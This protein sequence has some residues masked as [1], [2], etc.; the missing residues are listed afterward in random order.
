MG[1]PYQDLACSRDEGRAGIYERFTVL[2]RRDDKMWDD[3]ARGGV[4]GLRL[5]VKL[6]R[7]RICVLCN[8]REMII[9]RLQL[10]VVEIKKKM[11]K[12]M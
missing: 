4:R 1:I 8:E 10:W 3:E 9:K 11:F 2:K 12:Y 6:F 5:M 7:V